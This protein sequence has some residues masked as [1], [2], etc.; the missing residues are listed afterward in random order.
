MPAAPPTADDAL[1]LLHFGFREIVREPDAILSARGLGRLHHRILYMCRRNEALAVHDLLAVLEITKQALH[2]PLE[3]L[4]RQGLIDKAR[5]PA[6]GRTRRLVLTARGRA[7]ERQLSDP[8]RRAFTRAFAEVGLAGATSWAIAMRSL[9]SGKSE[10]SLL[11]AAARARPR[12][13]ARRRAQRKSRTR[14]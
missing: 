3:E 8:Q 5:D 11:A 13:H 9:A 10:A 4:V 12:S 14:S 6:D 2:G 7:L 1:A